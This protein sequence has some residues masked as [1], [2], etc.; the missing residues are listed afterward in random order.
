MVDLEDFDE[1]SVTINE[2]VNGDLSITQ[3]D[4]R[5]HG[6]QGYYN[7]SQVTY[8]D[9]MPSCGGVSRIGLNTSKCS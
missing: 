6:G 1:D 8:S 4:M 2:N 3:S 5:R 9:Q 7:E